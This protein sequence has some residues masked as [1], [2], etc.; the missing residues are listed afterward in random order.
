V[1]RVN[2]VLDIPGEAKVGVDVLY[3]R[4]VKGEVRFSSGKGV[5]R[6]GLAFCAFGEIEGCGEG[7]GGSV[8]WER[9]RY[10]CGKGRRR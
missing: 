3:A 8:N 10:L 7:R 4:F 2:C 1:L 5:G 6:E 9:S